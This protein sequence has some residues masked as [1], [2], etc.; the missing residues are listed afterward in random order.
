[1][2]YTNADQLPNKM[3]F[4]KTRVQLD[5]PDVIIIVEVNVKHM[6]IETNEAVFNIPHYQAHTK[7]LSVEGKR[8]I[9]IYTHDTLKNISEIIADT[10]FEEYLA[11]VMIN[12]KEK[13]LICA[14]YRSE[15]G[16]EENNNLLNELMKE[17]EQKK[18]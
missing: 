10:E 13:M 14:V 17:M 18:M 16:S 2:L 8:G 9:I 7:N 3:Q 15:G 4:L 1:M 12:K 6:R 11:L 5:K